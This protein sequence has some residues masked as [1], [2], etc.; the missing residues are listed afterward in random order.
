[1]NDYVKQLVAVASDAKLKHAFTHDAA[2]IAALK[3]EF[4]ETE[5][6]NKAL[7]VTHT[8][9]QSNY[10]FTAQNEHKLVF[11][12]PECGEEHKLFLV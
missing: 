10:N 2:A 11:F 4:D 3:A 8:D 9:E 1:M 12:A 6:P 7:L 5:T